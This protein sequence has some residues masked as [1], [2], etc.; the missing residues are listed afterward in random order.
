MSLTYLLDKLAA[1]EISSDPFPHI[2]IENF[3]EDNDFEAVVGSPEISLPPASTIHELFSALDAAD[4]KAIEFPGCTKSRA[5]YIAWVESKV[6][7]KGIHG[8]CEGKGMAMRCDQPQSEAVKSLDAFFQ[9]RELRELLAKKFG[10]TE[11][12]QLDCGLQKY[13]N[14]YEI[15]PHPD[16]RQKALT[17]M[18]NVNPGDNTEALDYHTHYMTFRP[19]WDFVRRFWQDTPDAETC[20]VPWQWCETQKRQTANNSIVVF[21]P[22][23]DTLHAIRAHYDHLPAQRTQF[24]GNLWYKPQRLTSRP[25]YRDFENGSAPKSSRAGLVKSTADRLRA[26][27]VGWTPTR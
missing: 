2:Y 1:A 22:R 11:P 15:S 7:L 3:L 26:Q 24:Y 4:Y 10:V 27:L 14:G 16:I 23:Y 17:W 20:W 12:T 9:T 13:L 18:L 6:K 19:E 8:A 21:S 25:Q 5:D